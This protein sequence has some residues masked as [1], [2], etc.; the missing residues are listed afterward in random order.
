MRRGAMTKR[1]SSF[2][3]H[4]FDN[5]D[6]FRLLKAAVKSEGGQT[7][8]AKRHRINRVYINMVL[9]GKRPVGDS[10]ARALGL[11]KVYIAEAITR[12]VI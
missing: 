11:R 10:I 9:K 6:V 4:V 1:N 8:F 12:N 3:A 5:D 2:D 7:V